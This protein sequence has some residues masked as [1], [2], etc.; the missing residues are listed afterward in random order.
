MYIYVYVST[1]KWCMHMYMHM[2]IVYMYMHMYMHIYILHV[3]ALNCYSDMLT[4]DDRVSS[5]EL[6]VDV[7]AADILNREEIEPSMF[8]HCTAIFVLIHICPAS[9][10]FPGLVALWE[11][12]Q[13]RREMLGLEVPLS[14]PLSPG[15]CT[16][17]CI[18]VYECV[19]VCTCTNI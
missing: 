12:E 8:V 15:T 2:Y 14:Q 10:R 3:Y 17:T 11:E 4:V 18:H 9:G 16:Y 6:E 1:Y 5:T 7:L 19:H 13:T